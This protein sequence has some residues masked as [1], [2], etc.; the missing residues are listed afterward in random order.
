MDGA[1]Q[2]TVAQVAHSGTA[3]SIKR[4]FTSP[5]VHPFETVE[6]E[7]RDARIGHGPVEQQRVGG[8]LG[9]QSALRGEPHHVDQARMQERLPEPDEGDGRLRP[10]AGS[11][12][13]D[14]RPSTTPS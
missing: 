4:L 11:F 2:T 8:D 14:V 12:P 3:L 9:R 6:W 5:G 13:G 7:L 10:P 1:T